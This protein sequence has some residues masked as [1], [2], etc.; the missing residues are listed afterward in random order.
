MT[1]NLINKRKYIGQKKS[2]VFLYEKYLGSG[3]ILLQAI[4]LYGASNFKVRLLQECSSKEELDL[5]EKYWISYYDAQKSRE[6]YNICKGG[7]SGP[8]GP[9]M[10]GKKHS[11]K[12]REIMSITRRGISNPNFGNRWHNSDKTK[13]IH[14]EQ[15]KGTKN[16]SYG[17]KLMNN[18][19]VAKRVTNE[20][21]EY[22]LNNGWKFGSLKYS[23]KSPTTSRKQI[24]N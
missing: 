18:G 20:E 17:K 19:V 13:S 8:G 12:T 11:I 2:N 1:T 23:K 21:F 14:S 4:A 22:Y 24:V 5:S 6:F 7:E 3:K 16:P 15:N 9:R 10:L